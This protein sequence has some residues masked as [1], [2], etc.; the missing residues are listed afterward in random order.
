MRV[1]GKQEKQ[2]RNQSSPYIWPSDDI[3][4]AFDRVEVSVELL[5]GVQNSHFSGNRI[6]ATSANDVEPL[7]PRSLV[8]FQLHCFQELRLTTN[9]NVMGTA[10]QTR[11]NHRFT[12]KPI[13]KE[14]SVVSLGF[15]LGLRLECFSRAF[16]I[17]RN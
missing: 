10:F 7:L 2:R 5:V 13:L 9:I 12:V 3:E 14:N 4:E 8:V 17:M 16:A 6:E 15:F 11:L 1:Q